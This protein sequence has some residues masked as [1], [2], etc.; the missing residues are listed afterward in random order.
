MFSQVMVFVHARN[1][2]VRTAM[3][4]KERA[5][6]SN[7]LK[8]FEPDENSAVGQAR[9]ALSRSRNKQLAELFPCGF[10]V[11]HAGMLRSDR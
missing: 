3:V 8:I 4:L 9:K 2:T 6:Q 7:Q 5:L 11:H 10:S 1:A